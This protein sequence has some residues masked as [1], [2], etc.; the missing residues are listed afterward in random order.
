ML[1]FCERFGTSRERCEILR[2]LLALRATLRTFG[3]DRG[4]WVDGSFAEDIEQ[5]RLRPP[6]DVDVVSFVPLGDVARQNTISAALS[7]PK[8]DF[9]VD[10]YFVDVDQPLDATQLRMISYWYSM[11]S[12]DR[13]QR[14]KGFCE[15]ALDDGTEA[16]AAALVASWFSATGVP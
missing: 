8:R 3:I 1:A 5:T 14:W 2:G 10:H 7:N 9:K 13:S 11:W 4:Q 12:H 6:A 15:L 16:D